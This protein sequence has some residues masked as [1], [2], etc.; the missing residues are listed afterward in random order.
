MSKK[1]QQQ[2]D[3]VIFNINA[4]ERQEVQTSISNLLSPTIPIIELK[5]IIKD[6][7]LQNKELIITEI[8]DEAERTGKM[9]ILNLQLDS[10][11][12]VPLFDA[13]DLKTFKDVGIKVSIDFGSYTKQNKDLQSIWKNFLDKVD[14]VFFGNSHDLEIAIDTSQVIP[15]KA[16]HIQFMKVTKLEEAEIL[17]RAANILISET[18]PKQDLLNETVGAITELRNSRIIIA[19][20]P[21]SIDD[22]ANIIATKFGII[23]T[24]QQLGIKLEVEDIL[25]DKI[26]GAKKLE[27]YILQ[28]SQQFK[29]DLNKTEINPID[30]YFD[31]SN[32][33]TLASIY[34]QAKYTLSPRGR[35]VESLNNGCIQLS[36]GSKEE[37][38]SEI[39][40]KE[41]NKDINIKTIHDMQNTLDEYKQKNVIAKTVGIF[42]RMAEDEQKILEQKAVMLKENNYLYEDNDIA[43]LLEATLK[44]NNKISIQPAISL[45]NENHHT[46]ISRHIIKESINLINNNNKDSAIIPINTG[47]EHWVALAITKDVNGEIFFTYNDPIGTPITQRT[48]LIEMIKELAPKGKI[49]DL[50][51][52]QQQNVY[53]CGAFV[54]DNLIKMAQSKNIL[55]TEESKNMGSK[56]RAKHAE[57]IRGEQVIKKACEI[58]NGLEQ[59]SVAQPL[60]ATHI[61]IKKNINISRNL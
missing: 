51:A 11:N 6:G 58:R 18:L 14:H 4:S 59:A 40:T 34:S 44:D 30:I 17:D 32:P 49:I 60:H 52:P 2:D 29:K 13:K 50:Q 12:N 31:L 23:D 7:E 10:N 54:V 27:N 20:P 5:D 45:S 48:N 15:N 56:L 26:G 24:N 41:T 38:I 3:I 47:H 57:I 46:E 21:S 22:V 39:Q 1:V 25:Q 55:T 9:P 61:F 36:C 19:S 16:S 53:D 42:R 35:S 33:K 8:L 37:I 43:I 28:L